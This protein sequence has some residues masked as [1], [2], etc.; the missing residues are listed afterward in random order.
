MVLEEIDK[1]CRERTANQ[2]REEKEASGS[3]QAPDVCGRSPE[4]EKVLIVTNDYRTSHQLIQV[5]TGKGGEREEERER[6]GGRRKEIHVFPQ[7]LCV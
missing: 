7:S 6:E 3:G 2:E 1:D 4:Q 5:C